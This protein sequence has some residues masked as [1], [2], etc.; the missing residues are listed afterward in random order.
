MPF[1]K[2]FQKAAYWAKS[3]VDRYGNPTVASPIELSVRWELGTSQEITP[4]TNP[5]AV[6]ATVWVDREIAVGSMMR[7]GELSELGP[8]TGSVDPPDNILEVV[9]YI[10][11]PSVQ[12]NRFE[13]IVLLRSFGGTLPTVV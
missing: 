13:R 5:T 3:S 12:A 10:E 7:K 1:N 6:D 8:G 4:Q 9:E 2:R 11:T